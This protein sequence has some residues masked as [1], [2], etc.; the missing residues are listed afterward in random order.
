MLFQPMT[1]SPGEG[2]PEVLGNERMDLGGLCVKL[3]QLGFKK[4]F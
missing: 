4:L 1:S 3:G 2:D